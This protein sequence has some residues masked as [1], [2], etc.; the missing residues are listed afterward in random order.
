MVNSAHSSEL[1][2]SEHKKQSQKKLY[3]HTPQA[4]RWGQV[5][6]RFQWG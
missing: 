6:R 1:P 3:S 4:G 2:L 5:A